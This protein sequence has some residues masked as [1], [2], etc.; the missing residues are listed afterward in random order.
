[1]SPQSYD[2]PDG[3]EGNIVETRKPDNTAFKQ[4]RLPAWQPILT[5]RSVLPTFFIVGIIFIPLGAVLLTVSNNVLEYSSDYTQCQSATGDQCSNLRL[6]ASRTNEPCVCTVNVTVEKNMQNPVYVYYGLSN[7]FQ[8][9]RRYVKSRDDNQL[10]G[11]HVTNTSISKDCAPYKVDKVNGSEWPIA[12]CGAIANSLFNDTFI[13]TGMNIDRTGIAWYTDHSVKFNNPHPANNLVEAFK[14]YAKPKFWQE[15]VDKL[16]PGDNA[17]NGYKNEALEVWMRTA[18][19]P[20]FRKLYGKIN[21]SLPPD[22]YSFIVNYN[23]PV[24]A[25]EGSK[26]LII[27]T[28]SFMGGKNPFL[29]IA[30]IVVGSASLLVGI[31]LCIIHFAT[32]NK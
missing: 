28:T 11:N 15:S 19:F 7:F 17:N 24:T 32:R 26:R 21:V 8:N 1:M 9:H 6:N 31:G 25:F 12:P 23:Y 13:L 18:A 4:Q 27:S 10:V 30:Y 14:S 22:N 2:I 3:A 16:D 29:G 20:T 5:P